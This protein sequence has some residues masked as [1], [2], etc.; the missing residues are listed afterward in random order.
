MEKLTFK[1]WLLFLG[2]P[3][4]IF[5]TALLFSAEFDHDLTAFCYDRTGFG[6]CLSWNF[7]NMATS[8]AIYFLTGSAIGLGLSGVGYVFLKGTSLL[9]KNISKKT[10]NKMSGKKQPNIPLIC[11]AAT[12]GFL[13]SSTT[14]TSMND[15][16]PET[17]CHLPSSTTSA[18]HDWNEK[19]ILLTGLY[20]FFIG[21][22]F[23]WGIFFALNLLWTLAKKVFKRS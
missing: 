4:A 2:L 6:E 18:C 21:A 1:R 15:L 5:V 17:L 9:I 7:K 20:Y 14:L 16:E 19:A 10:K 11:L 23:G 8:L 13:F 12:F 22:L 3:V